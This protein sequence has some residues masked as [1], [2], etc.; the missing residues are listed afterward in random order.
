MLAAA[1][2]FAQSQVT[3]F[4]N[5][6]PGTTTKAEVD[7]AFGDPRRKVSPREEIYDY[8]PPRGTEEADHI[9]VTFFPDTRVVAR[10]DV[11]FKTPVGAEPLRE[12][13]GGTRVVSRPHP[14]AAV[15]ELYYPRLHGLVLNATTADAQALAFCYLSQRYLASVYVERFDS[16]L[17]GKSYE[18]ALVEAEKAAVVDPDGA[19]GYLSQARYYEAIGN[20]DEAMTHYTTAGNAKTG[21]PEK[22]RAAIGLALLY[23]NY[24]KAF[25]RAEAEYKRALTLAMRGD[26]A[27]ARVKYGEFLARQKRPEEARA[28]FQRALELDPSLLSGHIALGAMRW[29][30]KEYKEALANYETIV[31]ATAKAVNDPV[32]ATALYRLGVTLAEAGRVDEALAALQQ[33]LAANAPAAE[34]RYQIGALY[35]RKADHVRAISEFREGLKAASTDAALNMGLTNSLIA[36]GLAVDAMRQAELSLKLAPQD[37]R[38]LFDVSRAYALLKKKKESIDYARR[39]VAAGFADRKALTTDPALASIQNEGDFKKLML[40]VR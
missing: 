36:A 1:P 7:L 8:A 22:Y 12:R 21:Q 29:E 30:N 39:A 24:R 15:E 20:R 31:A 14:P 32:R 38:R 27:D 19:Q 11:Y 4:L 16:L 5:I 23:E 17:A 2:A 18:A 35:A 26:A 6:L 34:T 3:A 40:Q 10:I 13:I 28:E 9:E 33:A 25:D 37:P